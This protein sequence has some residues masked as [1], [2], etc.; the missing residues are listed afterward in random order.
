MKRKYYAIVALLVGS[1]L[2]TELHTFLMWIN[3]QTATMYVDKWFIQP[4]FTVERL[5]ILWYFKMIEDT[6]LVASILFSGACQSYANNYE[7]YLQWQR[8]SF[9]L[10]IIWLIYF[11]YHIFDLIMFMYNYKTTYWL[12]IVVLSFSTSSAL[13][14][15]AGSKKYFFKK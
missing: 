9:R 15:A 1:H 6:L 12:Y 8:Y 10:Y 4:G 11:A 5:S 14:V 2:L 3:P 7:T 13:F